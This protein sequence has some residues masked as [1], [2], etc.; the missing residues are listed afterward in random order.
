MNFIEINISQNYVRVYNTH[1]HQSNFIL[2][3]MGKLRFTLTNIIFW[4]VLLLS[5]FLSENFAILNNNPLKGF[6]VDSAFILTVSTIVLLVIYYFL[7]H[8]KNGLTFDK[9]LLPSFIISGLLLVWTVFRQGTRTFVTS[10]GTDKLSFSF[11]LSDRFLAALAVFVWLAV[12]YALVFVY[13]RYRLNKESYRWVAKVYLIAV[14]IMCLIDV[15]VEFDKIVA[16]FNGTYQGGGLEF[17]LGNANVWSLLI[18]AGILTTVLL[19]YKHFK[20][21]YYIPMM[22]LCTYNIMTTCATTIYISTVL[23]FVYSLYEILSQ[24]KTNKKH[25]LINLAIFLGSI[26]S[27]ILL[28]TVLVAT[29]VPMFYNFWAFIENSIF[30]KD[31]LTMTGRVDIWKKVW[32]LLSNNPLDLIFGLGHKTSTVIF[33]EYM[34][35]L[36]SAHNACMEMVLRYGLIGMAGYIVIVGLTIYSLVRYIL[37]KNYR[38]AVIYGLCFVAIFAHSITE[39]TTLFTPNVGGLYFSF[40]FILPIINVLQE[41]RFNELKQDLV[42]VDVPKGK[43][44]ECTYFAIIIYFALCVII[45]KIV[46][47][48]LP[49]DLFSTILVLITVFM[50]GLI[51]ISLLRKNK[52]YNPLQILANNSLVYYR[53]LVRK[54]SNYEK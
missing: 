43:I 30:H 10:N 39:S 53:D 31:F 23:V 24:Y 18:F 50:I 27:T 25:S 47:L 36:R 32:Q 35:G 46:S 3:Y 15:F 22:A 42:N 49:I 34:G 26:I 17:F 33:K 7:E 44:K 12:I 13:N 37:K 38:F 6:S 51:I 28:F 11:T 8:K 4:I 48:V 16:I 21:Y 1:G 29:K 5:C 52:E 20:L 45:A 9:V 2:L 54:E 14:S 19:S 40:V 41:K